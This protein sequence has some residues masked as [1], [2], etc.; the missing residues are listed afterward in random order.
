MPIDAEGKERNVATGSLLC[1]IAVLGV[2]FVLLAHSVTAKNWDELWRGL[3]DEV[4][5]A[6]IVSGI[7]GLI[8]DRAL[9]QDL[10]RNAVAAAIG[11]LLPESLKAEL[12]WVYGQKFLV[13]QTFHVRL[14]HRPEKHL[15]F[16]HGH[17]TRVIRNTSGE[18]AE[19]RIGGGT[20]EWFN[21]E[22]ESRITTCG[23]TRKNIFTPIQPTK[24][25]VGIGYVCPEKIE[26]EPN[27]S[28]EVVMAYILTLGE[29]G[30][31]LLTHGYP[32]E[33]PLVT[34]EVPDTL[35]ARVVFSHRAK[36]YEESLPQ[37]GS[38]SRRLSG[39]LLPHQD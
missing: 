4:G 36:F 21:S 26:L 24:N 33:N 22:S 8:V 9:K 37:S 6:L 34:L 30:T 20:D 13:E 23:F 28:I 27:E 17:V 5:K 19:P 29:H 10:I 1:L 12:S 16:F 15:V 25:I 18:K 7:L 32:I 3:F 31:E 35:K 11:Y 38:I 14:E 39:M 2:C